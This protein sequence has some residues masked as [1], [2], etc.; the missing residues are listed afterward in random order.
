MAQRSLVPMICLQ[1]TDFWRYIGDVVGMHGLQKLWQTGSKPLQAALKR[2]LF[3]S[4]R[5]FLC[6]ESVYKQR[7]DIPPRRVPTASMCLELQAQEVVIGPW[8]K[9]S[10]LK[11]RRLA[12]FYLAS[13]MVTAPSMRASIPL[14]V[15]IRALESISW[16]RCWQPLT[17]VTLLRGEFDPSVLGSHAFPISLSLGP[18]SFEH[19][20]YCLPHAPPTQKQIDAA[21]EL[22]GDEADYVR[23]R[24][25]GR[26]FIDLHLNPSSLH[27]LQLDVFYT[28]TYI[29]L[30]LRAAFNLRSITAILTKAPAS[31]QTSKVAGYCVLTISAGSDLTHIYAGNNTTQLYAHSIWL[32][33]KG[34][35]SS[36]RSLEL[37]KMSWLETWNKD[38][39]GH[40]KNLEALKMVQCPILDA[41]SVQWPPL[42]KRL[43]LEE[44]FC[45]QNIIATQDLARTT[46]LNPA[47]LPR[48]L[49]SLIITSPHAFQSP[50]L[51]SDPNFVPWDP[52]INVIPTSFNSH[53]SHPTPYTHPIG[54]LIYKNIL[55]DADFPCDRLHTLHLRSAGD[56]ES[57]NLL[58][59][60]L[61]VLNLQRTAKEEMKRIDMSLDEAAV[62]LRTMSN[63]PALFD[64]LAYSAH[65]SETHANLR[66]VYL[67]NCIWT[68]WRPVPLAKR[69]RTVAEAERLGLQLP[70]SQLPEIDLVEW[71][72]NSIG[73][74]IYISDRAGA[75]GGRHATSLIHRWKH[76]LAKRALEWT[77]TPLL[78]DDMTELSIKHGFG[79]PCPPDPFQNPHNAGGTRVAWDPRGPSG[80]LYSAIFS[81]FREQAFEWKTF[82]MSNLVRLELFGM[83]A[84]KEIGFDIQRLPSLRQL[85]M[86][87]FGSAPLQRDLASVITPTL[88]ELVLLFGYYRETI[89][90]NF[91]PVKA[92][93]LRRIA[94]S[95]LNRDVAVMPFLN[96][97]T[98]PALEVL[99][100]VPALSSSNILPRLPTDFEFNLQMCSWHSY[101]TQLAKMQ[102]EARS[103]EEHM[104]RKQ[105]SL[106]KKRDPPYIAKG[107]SQFH[108]ATNPSELSPTNRLNPEASFSF[109]G[110]QWLPQER[111]SGIPGSSKTSKNKAATPK[112]LN[113]DTIRKHLTQLS[114]V[115]KL[116]QFSLERLMPNWSIPEGTETLDLSFD[117]KEASSGWTGTD[118]AN[119]PLAYEYCFSSTVVPCDLAFAVQPQQL[120]LPPTLTRLVLTS[121]PFVTTSFFESLPRTLRILHI[122]NQEQV[123]L[124]YDWN[125][126]QDG[127]PP[128]TIEDIYAP[129][130]PLIT[131]HSK[132]SE[133]P[134]SLTRLVC[135]ANLDERP[136][137]VPTHY[138]V[139]ILNGS[140]LKLQA[141]NAPSSEQPSEQTPQ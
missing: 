52:Q 41:W 87:G 60:S 90:F 4:L 122:F 65:L 137:K 124:T 12:Q 123:H 34:D 66:K 22:K 49:E 83:P 134:R 10:A 82:N 135:L 15:D 108:F 5:G 78:P 119:L 72:L 63:R 75:Y 48:T 77:L 73:D 114:T 76:S 19:L 126:N 88:E 20:H 91:E 25:P 27:S 39:A 117:A 89:S 42:L 140:I 70:A 110:F 81:S 30:D 104:A 54:L 112:T 13:F 9:D 138:K 7:G 86:T 94:I 105:P 18:C 55:Q 118:C 113:L 95:A 101:F 57:I 32:E 21:M 68:Y 106:Y 35:A 51:K 62:L 100:L 26:P 92:P 24:M 67:N 1:S 14:D 120:A 121:I 11:V 133:W 31:A 98:F 37:R 6:K 84:G 131:E 96:C 74:I 16:L 107:T 33:I 23:Y 80:Y 129:Q 111:P 139:L 38:T 28:H 44:S 17:S 130:I 43:T 127:P 71:L 47:H 128:P 2:V 102:A 29:H 40:L 36:L 45:D 8:P 99:E 115:V 103:V 109:S 93:K 141:S 125:T 97:R 61:V 50:I 79:P 85:C 116:H 56:V 3:G 59:S 136:A 64:K 132:F 58:P 46:L 53:A 69:Q